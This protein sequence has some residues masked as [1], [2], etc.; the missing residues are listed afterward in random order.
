MT[1]SKF[2]LPAVAALLAATAWNAP[3]A[4]ST[5]S[6]PVQAEIAAAQSASAVIQTLADQAMTELTDESLADDVRRQKF[7]ALM[8]RYF[9]MDVV[10][11]F[12]LGRYWRSISNEEINEFSKL[13]QNYLA[14]N[15]ANQFK[16]FNGE[17]FVVGSETEKNKDTFV[18]S[19][20]VRPDGPPVNIVWRM[21]MFNDHYKI[22]DVAIEGLSMGITQRDEFTSVIQ[23]NNDDVGALTAALKAKTGL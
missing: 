4:A 19:Q 20:F 10:S 8:D 6:A 21:R 7:V 18:N 14:L 15:Y 16:A 9:E 5:A 22:I 3:V 11:R 23:Q 1:K 12:V 13:L 17:Q 2:I